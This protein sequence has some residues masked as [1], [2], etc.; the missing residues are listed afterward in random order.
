MD[1][2]SAESWTIFSIAPEMGR[3]GG[4]QQ[5]FYMESYKDLLLLLVKRLKKI[6]R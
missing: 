1:S 2:N 6:K 3:D 5:N 4:Q